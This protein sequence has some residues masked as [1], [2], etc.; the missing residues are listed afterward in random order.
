M[1]KKHK[2]SRMPC[3]ESK[4]VSNTKHES[5]ADTNDASHLT[6]EASKLHRKSSKASSTTSKRTKRAQK[7]CQ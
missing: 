2:K 7:P 1:R 3:R 5:K 6:Q 4:S